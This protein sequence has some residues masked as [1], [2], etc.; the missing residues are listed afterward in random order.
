MSDTTLD[1]DTLEIYQGTEYFI[2]LFLLHLQGLSCPPPLTNPVFVLSDVPR[3]VAP[4]AIHHK[5][6]LIYFSRARP[7]FSPDKREHLEKEKN[8]AQPADTREDKKQ[9]Q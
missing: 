5:W 1:C 2:Y 3:C 8:L 4:T 9:S 6:L 7:P